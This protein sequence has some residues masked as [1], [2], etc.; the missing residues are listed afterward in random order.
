MAYISRLEGMVQEAARPLAKALCNY[1]SDN[2]EEDPNLILTQ[3]VCCDASNILSIYANRQGFDMTPVR[4][5]IPAHL[6]PLGLSL[7]IEPS[8]VLL[9]NEDE[10]VGVDPTYLQYL[11]LVG[12]THGLRRAPEVNSKLMK[13]FPEKK[14]A[15]FRLGEA[16]VFGE[17][18]A[19]FALEVRERARNA[20]AMLSRDEFIA[21]IGEY[22]QRI[23]ERQAQLLDAPE[24][25]VDKFFGELWLAERYAPYPI[26][27]QVAKYGIDP[28]RVINRYGAIVDTMQ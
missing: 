9:H 19:K 14:I 22:Q 6:L 7:G 15:I 24:A 25:T 16:A 17:T 3:G 10:G 21:Q 18:V 13:L 2:T 23:V 20:L 5:D 12:L 27:H 26:S 8:H 4:R 28:Q 11:C 1:I